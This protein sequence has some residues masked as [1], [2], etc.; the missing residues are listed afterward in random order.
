MRGFAGTIALTALLAVSA[1]AQDRDN[2]LDYYIVKVRPEKRADFDAVARKIGD[3]NRKNHGDNWLAYESVYGEN[4]TIYFASSRQNMAAID[5]ASEAFMK[6]LKEAFGANSEGVLQ[7]MND[8]TISSRG[9]LRRRRW[10][11]SINPAQDQPGTFRAVGGSRWIRTTMVRV[12]PGHAPQFEQL[13]LTVKAAAEKDG[14]SPTTTVTQVVA[15]QPGSVYYLTRLAPSLGAFESSEI[16]I[17]KL[18]GDEDYEKFQKTS[19]E[20]ILGTETIY[21]RFLPELSNP[22]EMVSSVNPDF[23]IPKTMPAAPARTKGKKNQ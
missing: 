3:A 4:N 19:A 20:C 9:E 23:W 17:K 14:G 11:L 21:G 18:L 16:N 15:G 7:Q 22:P 6:A 2:Y 8:A 10:D 13:A 1:A 12:R 5:T